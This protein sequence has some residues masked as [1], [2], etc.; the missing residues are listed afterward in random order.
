MESIDV[1]IPIY[2]AAEDLARCL[3][4]VAAHTDLTRHRVMLV[5][6]GPQDEA[7]ESI[8]ASFVGSRVLRNEQRRGFVASVNRGM[9]ESRSDVVLLN[10]DA[11]VTARWLEKLIDAAYSSRNIGTVTPL[12]NNAT[13]CSVPRA[14]EENFIPSGYDIDSFAAL[15][16]KASARVY[17]LLPTGVGFC[18]YIRRALLDDIGFFDE[19][20]FGLGYG[21][22][23]DFCMRALARG[24]VHAADDATF[25]YH[26]GHRSFGASR[27]SRQRRARL[28]LSLRHPRYMATIG[29]FMRR[30]P[31]APVRARHMNS[32]I[33]AM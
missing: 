7:V 8:V 4:S 33:V 23:N 20:R 2:G 14:S 16:E 3:G 25:I 29:E 31:L 1:V 12:S 10:S 24:W 32:P 13:I 21:E 11:I 6:D 15:V 5:V 28:S 17:P 30:D 27:A 9:R 22:E 26:A 19:R 18:L